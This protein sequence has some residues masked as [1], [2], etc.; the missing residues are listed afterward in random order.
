MNLFT[1]VAAADPC[2]S[3]DEASFGS[4][5]DLELVEDSRDVVADR[6]LAEEQRRC[7]LRVGA[8]LGEQLEYLDLAF[9]ELRERFG[10]IG[11]RRSRE[12]ALQALADASLSPA[13]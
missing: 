11:G 5:G 9:G 8:A 13:R 7:D 6:L 4:V 12:V 2:G 1:R 3:R 10:G